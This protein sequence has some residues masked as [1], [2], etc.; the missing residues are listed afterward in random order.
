MED[1]PLLA[2]IIFGAIAAIPFVFMFLIFWMH[3][4]KMK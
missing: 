1:P 3:S 4:G 2:K